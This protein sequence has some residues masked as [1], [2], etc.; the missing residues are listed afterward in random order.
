MTLRPLTEH[1]VRIAAHPRTGHVT[2][3]AAHRC[4]CVTRGCGRTA[5]PGSAFCPDCDRHV[6]RSVA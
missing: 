1:D 5:Q 2:V 6:R 4:S 3:Q